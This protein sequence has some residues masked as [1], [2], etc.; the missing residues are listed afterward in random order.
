MIWDC[1]FIQI[2]LIVMYV[3]LCKYFR[4]YFTESM[5]LNH[6]TAVY[7]VYHLFHWLML[8]LLEYITNLS[9]YFRFPW[10][11]PPLRQTYVAK[12]TVD[13][14]LTNQRVLIMPRIMYFFVILKRYSFHTHIEH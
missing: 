13:A 3:Q 8:L 9:K 7:F 6:L 10:L 4:F 1:L 5:L 11:F 2:N 12:K 14:I